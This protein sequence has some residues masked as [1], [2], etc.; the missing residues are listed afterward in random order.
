MG[1]IARLSVL[2]FGIIGISWASVGVTAITAFLFFLLQTRS[3]FVPTLQ[4][5]TRLAQELI[6]LAFPLMLNNLLNA[7]FFRFDTFII[8]TFGGGDGNVLVG[9]YDTA[10]KIINIA[11][12]LPP[13][14]TFAVFPMLARRASSDREGLLHAQNRTLQLL[15]LLGFPLAMGLSVL[16]PNM[17]AL[18]SGERATEYLPISGD[19][20]AILAWFLP[21]SFVNGLIQYVLIAVNRQHAITKAFVIGAVF[22]VV[23]NI[24]F[25]P[26]FGL[27]AA[28]T[29]T[30]LS[31][32]VLLLVFL[33]M[34]RSEKLTPPLFALMWRPILS[35]L[36]MGVIMLIFQNAFGWWAAVL[37][38][39][40][41]YAV[42]LWL[43][44]AIGP[45]EQ[46]LA[47]RVLGRP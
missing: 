24:I 40:P 39:A 1:F 17:I 29:I 14:V 4:W 18:V 16:A 20:L 38:A 31:E 27:Y 45:E 10:Y 26:Q 36:A 13:V 42:G 9:Q 2:S 21:L 23:S 25:I 5:D 43:T 28:S 44:G 41:V 3:F 19:V 15:F 34:L 6:P 33:P 22:N 46:A 32:V 11:M 37:I 7:V 35:S 47:R 8:K 30:V 12:I